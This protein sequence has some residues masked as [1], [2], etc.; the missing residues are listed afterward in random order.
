MF[1]SSLTLLAIVLLEQRAS[2]PRALFLGFSV[3][4]AVSAKYVGALLLIPAFIAVLRSGG[5]EFRIN[6][7]VEFGLG[8]LFAV[9]VINF[10]AVA[11]FPRADGRFGARSRLGVRQHSVRFAEPGPRY[12][13]ACL[14][15]QYDTGDLAD[16]GYFAVGTLDSTP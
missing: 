11:D 2:V 12:V 4:I 9:L 8:L 3:A 16:A 10:F 15:A 14:V 7:I 6:R 13:L 1:G 5:K